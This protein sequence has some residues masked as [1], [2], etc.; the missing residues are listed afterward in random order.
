MAAS[1]GNI[2]A[3]AAAMP[4]GFR[5]TVPVRQRKWTS[6]LTKARAYDRWDKDSTESGLAVSEQYEPPEDRQEAIRDLFR[7][8]SRRSR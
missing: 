4:K 7:E 8:A 2:L 1:V 5:R 6:D 3:R